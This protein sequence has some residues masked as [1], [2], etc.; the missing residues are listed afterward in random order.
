MGS[1]HAEL[2]NL[3]ES[4]SD[5]WKACQSP[6]EFMYVRKNSR[7]FTGARRQ[8]FKTCLWAPVN[9]CVFAQ[10]I[11]ELVVRT[12]HHGGIQPGGC[13]SPF[14]MWPN[15]AWSVEMYGL[16]ESRC[17]SVHNDRYHIVKPLKPLASRKP[18]F[19][20][21]YAKLHDKE[22]YYR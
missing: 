3:H 11:L 15:L 10:T 2:R 22:S 14:P 17:S 12:C 5:P 4:V 1:S 16:G 6:Y 21:E 18:W 20:V 8:I 13:L 7:S 19:M 9:E